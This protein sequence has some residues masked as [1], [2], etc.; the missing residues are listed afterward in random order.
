MSR[1]PGEDLRKVARMIEVLIEAPEGLWLREIAKRAGIHPTTVANYANSLLSPILD[2]VILGKDE[3][4]ILRVLK[5]KDEVL[6]RIGRGETI[7]EILKSLVM[8][9]YGK[10]RI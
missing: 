1:P 6:E 8:L 7:E 9:K 5:L 3:K 2:D 10:Q 4:P